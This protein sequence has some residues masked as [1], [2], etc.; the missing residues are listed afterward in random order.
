MNEFGEFIGFV[1]AVSCA[2]CTAFFA[3]FAFADKEISE[4][5]FQRGYMVECV[6]KAGYYWECEE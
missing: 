5:A 2:A 6:G 4:Q 3:G 1:V